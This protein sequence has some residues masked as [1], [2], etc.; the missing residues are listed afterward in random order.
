MAQELLNNCA[1]ALQNI[2]HLYIASRKTDGTVIDFPLEYNTI[3]GSSDS[4][5]RVEAW[6]SVNN[7]ALIG[8]QEL[9]WREV[10]VLTDNIEFQEEYQ[11]TKQGKVYIK[12]L[13]F[14]L[15]K[16]NYTTNAA[17][18][19]FL[20]TANGEFAISNAIAFVIDENGSQWII[21]YDLPLILMD[22]MELGLSTENFYK[23]SFQSVGTSRIR[24]YQI[25]P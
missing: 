2:K 20:F 21:G 25:Q 8:G 10:S 24:N 19:E 14:S 1:L 23:L 9:D 15:P 13:T 4:I 22:G 7:T 5:I 17:L 3:S 11:L 12:V 16:V 6:D 18:K